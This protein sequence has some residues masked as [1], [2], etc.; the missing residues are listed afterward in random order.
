MIDT[1]CFIKFGMNERRLFRFILIKI[2]FVTLTLTHRNI[3][4]WR[5]QKNY[6]DYLFY[7]PIFLCVNFFSL[8]LQQTFF[9]EEVIFDH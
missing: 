6:N 1:N 2:R 7:V 4:T 8:Q 9:D 5:T 3:D